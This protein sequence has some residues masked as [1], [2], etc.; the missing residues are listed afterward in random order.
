MIRLDFSDDIK[1]IVLE[2]SAS[3]NPSDVSGNAVHG[4]KPDSQSNIFNWKNRLAPEEIQRIRQA[5]E[6][7][8]P[9]FY[10]DE[11]W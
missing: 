10:T 1:Q 6:D 9:A 4:L 2:H 11:D 3:S 5:T 8:S 7:I